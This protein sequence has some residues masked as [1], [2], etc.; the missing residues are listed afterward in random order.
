MKPASA[1]EPATSAMAAAVLSQD[2][3]RRTRQSRNTYQAEKEFRN[4]GVRHGYHLDLA[5]RAGG[6]RRNP[7]PCGE[8]VNSLLFRFYSHLA[9]LHRF[10]VRLGLVGMLQVIEPGGSKQVSSAVRGNRL[11][12]ERIESGKN[13]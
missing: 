5:D 1:V 3:A 8:P 7:S 4:G 9:W 10:W 13:G 11:L 12:G 2:G 6:G